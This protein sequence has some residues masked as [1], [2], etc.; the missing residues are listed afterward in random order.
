MTESTDLF[1]VIG[2]V[3]AK[4]NA[5][6]NFTSFLLLV[7]GYVQIRN[8]KID[9]H[10]KC[11]KA[12]FWTS[13]LFLVSYLTRFALTGAHKFPVGGWL[14]TVYL[15]ILISHMILAVATVPL[16]LRTLFL[17]SR[18][19]FVEHRKIAKI[20]Y[21]IWLYVSITGVLVYVLLYHAYA[22]VG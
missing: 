16:V 18:K 8:K 22:W 7:A 14:K 5:G 4:V 3:L 17:A 10:R 21:P 12:A 6:L 2:G 13:A 20:T 11:M 1:A 15:S 9:L 19:R